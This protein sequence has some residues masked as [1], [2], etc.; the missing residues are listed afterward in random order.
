MLVFILFKVTNYFRISEAYKP[1]FTVLINFSFPS[2]H[3][4]LSNE[5]KMGEKTV[6][7]LS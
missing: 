2:F 4:K 1:I 7:G 3:E 5:P 6:E